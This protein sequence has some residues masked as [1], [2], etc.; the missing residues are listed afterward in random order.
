MHI[1]QLRKV[2]PRRV[3][4]REC[5]GMDMVDEVE[6]R[7]EACMDGTNTRMTRA[8]T[9]TPCTYWTRNGIRVYSVPGFLLRRQLIELLLVF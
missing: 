6:M 9:P 8:H 5:R 4:G 2:R 1:L 3:M 7:S